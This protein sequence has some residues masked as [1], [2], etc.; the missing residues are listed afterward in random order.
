MRPERFERGAQRRERIDGTVFDETPVLGR[1]QGFEER[2][3]DLCERHGDRMAIVAPED[4]SEQRA[5]AIDEREGARVLRK[6][7]RPD[8]AYRERERG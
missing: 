8:R 6:I 2:R 7:A 3:C 4:R 1:A 5:V